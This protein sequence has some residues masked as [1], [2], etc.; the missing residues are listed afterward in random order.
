MAPPI[1]V[2]IGVAINPIAVPKA[3]EPVT[4]IVERVGSFASLAFITASAVIVSWAASTAWLLVLASAEVMSSAI[5]RKAWFTTAGSP[6]N[7]I[8]PA[9]IDG[10]PARPKKIIPFAIAADITH[11][12]LS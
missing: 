2:T 12:F 4:F 6:L 3:I 9:G 11:S 7:T 8:I 1:G 5:P 10:F